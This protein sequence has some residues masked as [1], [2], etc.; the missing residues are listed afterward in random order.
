VR[1]PVGL[2]GYRFAETDDLIDRLA[3]EI[4]VRD[5]E[6]ARLRRT[7]DEPLRR[8]EHERLA[9]PAEAA[10]PV[11]DPSPDEEPARPETDRDG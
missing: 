10:E 9:G 1:I 7:D 11:P 2:R 4:V 6:I 8:P 5:E 3:A